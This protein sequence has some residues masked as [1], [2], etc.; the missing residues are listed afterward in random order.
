MRQNGSNVNLKAAILPLLLLA[1]ACTNDK[2]TPTP[3]TAVAP[4]L[5]KS[6]KAVKVLHIDT[7]VSLNFSD[8]KI[9]MAMPAPGASIF[10]YTVTGN[11]GVTVWPKSGTFSPNGSDSMT[12]DDQ[13]V[14]SFKLYSDSLQFNF[15]YHGSG[16]VNRSPDNLEGSWK[17]FFIIQ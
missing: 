2:M 16:F 7:D 17:M 5:Y 4:S 14:I 15:D 12:R 10:A 8:F 11:S 13:T 1:T 6:W 9:V 3:T